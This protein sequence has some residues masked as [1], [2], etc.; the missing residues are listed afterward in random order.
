MTCARCQGLMVSDRFTDLLDDSGQLRFNGW[1][2]II[3]GDVVD[4][5][6]VQNRNHKPAT[7]SRPR[8]RQHIGV[9]S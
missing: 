7:S 1:R 3:C 6:I 5:I 2:C 4:P 9:Y 8:P